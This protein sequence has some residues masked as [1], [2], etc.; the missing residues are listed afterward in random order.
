MSD[1]KEYPYKY[2]PSP[3]EYAAI[4]ARKSTLLENNSI[5]SQ[6][7]IAKR[8]I[9]KKGLFLFNIYSDEESATKY[10]PTHRP[11]FKQLLYDAKQGKFKTL[12]VFRR[13]R[14]ARNVQDLLHIKK[15]FKSLD[16]EIVYSNEGEFQPDNSYISSFIENIIMSVDELEPA[17]LKERIQ[18]GKDEKRARGEHSGKPPFGY[19]KDLEIKN[20]AY[21][22]EK[23]HE[24]NDDTEKEYRPKTYDIKT[25]INNVFEEFIT[26]Q[27]T[28][29]IYT[30]IDKTNKELIKLN[31]KKLNKTSLKT[32]L[33]N[34]VY[35]GLI[36][37]NAKVDV[38]HYVDPEKRKIYNPFFVNAIN[39]TPSVSKEHYYKALEKITE[40]YS[41]RERIEYE[42]PSYIFK[43]LLTCARCHDVVYL[44]KGLYQCVDQCTSIPKEDLED[45]LLMR[46][47][48]D[49]IKSPYIKNYQ[50]K[51]L[52]EYKN[53]II[54]KEKELLKHK[55][56]EQ[57]E[58]RHLIKSYYGQY[59]DF[60]SI[61][62]V[63]NIEQEILEKLNKEKE[64]AL[65]FL[66]TV[67]E[68]SNINKESDMFDMVFMFK[69]D[70]DYSNLL[71]KNIIKRI[72]VNV[73]EEVNF[74][75]DSSEPRIEYKW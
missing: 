24:P 74:F 22:T 46:I 9:K 3:Q 54:R 26:L 62:K 57:N 28:S 17:I 52:S 10:H 75:N 16:I 36:K 37:L 65:K 55:D 47:I 71:L 4:Y 39:I 73:K 29:D 60:S 41:E 44:S 66:L 14:L 18:A 12:V 48:K 1:E 63:F 38:L 13:D 43:G 15:I 49:I 58:L 25:L 51:K 27:K 31:E 64:E 72:K 50:N 33:S 6:I 40:I 56:T 32:L 67:E 45:Y 61:K 11:G 8:K 30:L 5:E 35:A 23:E 34:P 53:T 69:S 20:E 68:L 7:E 59:V 42:E 2:L 70:E 21:R 19:K